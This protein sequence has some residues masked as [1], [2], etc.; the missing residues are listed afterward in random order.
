MTNALNDIAC[1]D[2]APC[3]HL[4]IISGLYGQHLA[5]HTGLPADIYFKFCDKSCRGGYGV[6]TSFTYAF[7]MTALVPRET[8]LRFA[9]QG[10]AHTHQ[11]RIET[12]NHMVLLDMGCRISQAAKRLHF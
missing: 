3:T 8:R 7:V 2:V 9:S 6:E 10:C 12:V 5:T 1:I 11:L 4:Q